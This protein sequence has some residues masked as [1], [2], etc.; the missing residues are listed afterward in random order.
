MFLG[1]VLFGAGIVSGVVIDRSGLALPALALPLASPS[2]SPTGTAQPNLS[3][4][5]Q[6]WDIVE[7]HYVN[8]GALNPTN[9]LYGAI[10]GM[11]DSL[12]DTGHTRFLTPADLS[13]EQQSLAG[14]LE[15]IGA[16]MSIRGGH[17]VIVAPIT[18]SPAAK[19]GIR[20]GDVLV[21]VNGQD[22]TQLPLD[23][24]VSLIH[25][26][27]GTPVTL[28]VIHRGQ[29]TPTDIT[30]VRAQVT[31]PSVTWAIVPGTHVAHVQVSQF[32]QGATKD[33]VNA[34][35]GAEAQGATSLVL[36]LRDDPGGL[37][38]EAISVAS[39]FLTGGNVL[40]E[41]NAQ[42]QRTTYPVK[43]NGVAPSIPIAVLVNQ[44][45]ASSAEI[46]AGAL[47][48]QKRGDLVGE[49]TFGT[50]TVLSTFRLSD[51]SAILLGT[52]EWLTPSGRQIW[53]QGI[54]PNVV[55]ALPSGVPPLFPDEERSMS[56]AEVAARDDTQLAAA[57]KAASHGASVIPVSTPSPAATPAPTP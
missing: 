15:G 52:S 49:K 55:V 33:L 22:V 9:M 51:G 30:I 14:R 38:D 12:G 6:A 25:G 37:R 54:Q 19:A 46:V 17:P 28:T 3:L 35:K 31:V 8:R 34:I 53:H 41:Q 29:T 16:E 10:T 11:V 18:G 57:V 32:A 40:I 42:G 45:T 36:D 26:P 24:I 4:F 1:L 43:P 39:Q 23:Q 20:A 2:P 5:Q 13:S 47:Q 21:R 44:G 27:L 50:G 56:A 7:Q 48:D